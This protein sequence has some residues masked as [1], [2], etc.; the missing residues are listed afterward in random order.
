MTGKLYF[1]EKTGLNTQKQ[2]EE[3]LGFVNRTDAAHSYLRTPV[4]GNALEKLITPEGWNGHHLSAT[5]VQNPEG[6]YMW[7]DKDGQYVWRS[8]RAQKNLIKPEY[9]QKAKDD[10]FNG[11]YQIFEKLPEIN[12]SL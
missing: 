12:P 4:T 8:Y 3:V 7:K 9:L 5:Q 10:L 11:I 2:G 6:Q 1:D